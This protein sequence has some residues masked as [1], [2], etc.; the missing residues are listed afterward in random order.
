MS[1]RSVLSSLTN[2]YLNPMF[3][4]ADQ[5]YVRV[6]GTTMREGPYTVVAVENGHYKLCDN[7]RRPV[8]DDSWLK[9]EE[10]E[11]YDPFE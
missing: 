8:K 5:V 3:R 1:I 4:P 7:N 9:E 10:L 11:F 6:S 2:C